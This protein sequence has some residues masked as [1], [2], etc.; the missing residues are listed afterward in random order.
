MAATY[1]MA[2][3]EANVVHFR[4]VSNDLRFDLLC[5][6]GLDQYVHWHPKLW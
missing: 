6:H 5:L 3:L 2:C 1:R 4:I